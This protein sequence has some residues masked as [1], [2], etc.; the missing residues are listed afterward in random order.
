[1]EIEIQKNIA[2]PE[3]GWRSASLPNYPK[4]GE[5]PWSQM[6]VGDSFFIALQNGGDVVRLMNRITGSGRNVLGAGRASA[7]CVMEGGQIGVRC[8]RIDQ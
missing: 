1:V 4:S 5:Y 7:R 6:S 2:L 3:T 8:W